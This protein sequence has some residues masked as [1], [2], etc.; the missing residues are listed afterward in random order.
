MT[1]TQALMQLQD[2]DHTVVENHRRL[3]EIERQLRNNAELGTAEQEA[4]RLAQTAE[5]ARK[6]QQALEFELGQLQ[7]K[8]DLTESNLYSGRITNSREL[9]DLQ[10]E[11]QSLRRRIG[12][13]ENALLDAMM[14]REEADDAARAAAEQLEQIRRRLAQA[15]AVLVTEQ[16]TLESRNAA[17]QVEQQQLRGAVP[18]EA[19]DSYDYLK[20]RTGHMPVAQLKSG[21]CSVCGTEVL[22]PT[23]Q[24]VQRGQ[25]AYCDTCLRLLVE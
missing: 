12:E 17:L 6:Q 22:R 2:L 16:A 21:V 19:L 9:Q 7:I 20:D 13:L 11:L 18:P 15:Q 23:Q 10:T 8:R 14:A 25:I 24:K 4:A 5:R 1:W 3:R